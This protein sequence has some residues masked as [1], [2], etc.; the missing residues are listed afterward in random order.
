M[1]LFSPN[2][3]FLFFPT[4]MKIRVSFLT[5]TKTF[6]YSTYCVP[7]MIYSRLNERF[8]KPNKP[9]LYLLESFRPYLH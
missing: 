9:C 4:T 3:K 7:L 5:T 2:Y 1:E 6:E 8:S